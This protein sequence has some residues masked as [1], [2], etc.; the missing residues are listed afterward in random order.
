MF[1]NRCQFCNSPVSMPDSLCPQCRK[2]A[3]SE[4]FDSFTERCPVCSMPLVSLVYRC[5]RCSAGGKNRIF[6]IYDYRAPF[7]RHMLEQWKFEGKRSHTA[8][9]AQEY[10]SAL[11]TL[12]PDLSPV[13]LVPVP[14]SEESLRKRKWDQMKDVAL[15]LKKKHGIDCAFLIENRKV[16]LNQ[17]KT[18]DRAQRISAAE[19]KYGINDKEAVKTDRSRICVVLD[20]ITTT[21]STIK[22]CIK[23]LE[24]NG[25]RNGTAV[26]LMAE[27]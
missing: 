25:F 9:F 7:F 23:L 22:S 15:Y 6:S 21:G 19:G 8:L 11:K 2:I 1:I 13:V 26:T 27:I 17:Q 20:D 14:C 10:L 24:N 4:K 5:P 16:T 12:Y 3:D 18:L